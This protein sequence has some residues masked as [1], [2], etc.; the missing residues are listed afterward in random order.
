MMLMWI[1]M[2]FQ[3]LVLS[4]CSFLMKS[5]GSWWRRAG[6]EIRLR[7]R[8]W[9]LYSQVCKASWDVCVMARTRETPALK[10][11]PNPTHTHTRTLTAEHTDRLHCTQFKALT[12]ARL[13]TEWHVSNW[14]WCKNTEE[15][16][17]LFFVFPEDSGDLRT[18]NTHTLQSQHTIYD[19]MIWAIQV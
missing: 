4:V 12:P 14:Q 1:S 7:D 18:Q 9:E 8:C 17:N 19:Q 13:R 3:V 16:S 15:V 5:A 6:T 10:T 11:P 2:M